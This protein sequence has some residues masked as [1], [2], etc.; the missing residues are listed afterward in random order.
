M[1]ELDRGETRS[2]DPA[3]E[4]PLPL[5]LPKAVLGGVLMG[6]ANLVPGVSGGTML[7]AAGVYTVFIG[8]IADITALRLRP[9]SLTVVA[10][11]AASAA[12][13]ILLLAGPIKGL[14]VEHR[15]MAYSLFIGLT[16]GGVPVIWRMIGNASRQI[17]IWTAV[18]FVGMG[19]IAW[20]QQYGSAGSGAADG[21][22][23]MLVVAGLAGASAMILPGISG[24]YL[25]LILGQYI[26]ILSAV[27]TL[28]QALRSGDAAAAGEVGLAVVLP[29]GIGLVIGVAGVSNVLKWL[30]ARHRRATLGVLLGLLLGA[31]VGLWPFQQGVE[32]QPGEVVGGEPLTAG[33]I[34]EMPPEEY[35]TVFFKPDA[36]EVGASLGLIAAGF[37][38]TS[39]VSLLERRHKYR[40]SS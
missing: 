24:G 23:P 6:L 12:L 1:S 2:G 36:A 27:D 34:A 10:A 33:E 9:R 25:L 15:W 13:G 26:P 7:L 40:K 14:V 20:V 18:G 30:L 28:K 29:V 8:A 16:L 35:P 21:S 31:V 19:L 38:V 17:F 3:G 5:L 39:A 4:L 11:V 22:W 32:P 37:A